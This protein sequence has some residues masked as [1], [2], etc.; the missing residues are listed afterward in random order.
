MIVHIMVVMFIAASQFM[1]P[2]HDVSVLAPN[3][4]FPHPSPGACLH[5]GVCLHGLYYIHL[6]APR[7]KL[8]QHVSQAVFLG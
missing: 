1:L 4:C 3:P 8:C 6:T 5:C 7:R 2:W